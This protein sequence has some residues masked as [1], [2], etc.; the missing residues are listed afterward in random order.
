MFNV[1]LI[2]G[3][4]LVGFILGVD[5]ARYFAQELVRSWAGTFSESPLLPLLCLF[6]GVQL[7]FEYR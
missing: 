4:N 6:V 3:A 2:V 5:G 7:M 1:L